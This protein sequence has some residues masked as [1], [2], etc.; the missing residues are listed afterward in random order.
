MGFQRD[1]GRLN[2]RPHI[3]IGGRMRSV[4]AVLNVKRNN[5][6]KA[7]LDDLHFLL[8]VHIVDRETSLVDEEIETRVK[9][10]QELLCQTVTTHR[11]EMSHL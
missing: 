1:H 4:T 7:D 10:D 2:G 9:T 11:A 5:A 8:V 6:E 3:H